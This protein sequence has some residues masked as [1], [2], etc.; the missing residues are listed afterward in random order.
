MADKC[1][2]SSRQGRT[3]GEPCQTQ[4]TR[5]HILHDYKIALPGPDD[6]RN[7]YIVTFK[8]ARHKWVKTASSSASR[9]AYANRRRVRLRIMI[10][11]YSQFVRG[12][13][14]A[15]S[16]FINNE[17]AQQA[18]VNAE[19]SIKFEVY[20]ILTNN[21]NDFYL[22]AACKNTWFIHYTNYLPCI[23]Y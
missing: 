7:K 3:Y 15:R 4:L 22:L 14:V 13:F 18:A 2:T 21:T 16:E 8:N 19:I 1:S 20:D 12:R 5:S 6:L 9:P 10:T 11:F 23:S 17:L